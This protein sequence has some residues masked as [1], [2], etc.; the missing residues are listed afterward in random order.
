MAPLAGVARQNPQTAY[1]GLYKSLHQ[2]WAF[3]KRVTPDTGMAFQVVEDALREMLLPAL[4]Q[5][6]TS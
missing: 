6:V 1:T 4:F 5:G 2:E 3:V